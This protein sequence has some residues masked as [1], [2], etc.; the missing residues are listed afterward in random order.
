MDCLPKIVA[1]VERWRLVEV[2]LYASTTIDSIGIL[3]QS[4]DE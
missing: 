1:V 2:R 4:W 3:R